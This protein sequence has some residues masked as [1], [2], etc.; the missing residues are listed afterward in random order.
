MTLS[1]MY[2]V[3]RTCGR[4]PKMTNYQPN[5]PHK[6]PSNN[7][8]NLLGQNNKSMLTENCPG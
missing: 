3:M 8:N 2:Y 4:T 1:I 6:A 7:L 5:F